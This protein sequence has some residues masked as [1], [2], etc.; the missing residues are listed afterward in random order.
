M[1]ASGVE[2][3]QVRPVNPTS[4]L[5]SRRGA[6]LAALATAGALAASLTRSPDTAARRRNACQV[7]CGG[8]RRFCRKDCRDWGA[9]EKACKRACN[10]L[11]D[12]CFEI[13]EFHPIRSRLGR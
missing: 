1:E 6:M 4:M 9:A 12:A 10:K 8:N 13:C 5:P 7:R 11:R 2:H 3:D